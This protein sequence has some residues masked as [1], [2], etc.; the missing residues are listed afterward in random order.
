MSIGEDAAQT[1]K[2]LLTGR[3]IARMIYEHCKVSDTDESVLDFSEI[4]KGELKNDTQWFNRDEMK[5]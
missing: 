2:R 3:H 5:P 1:G 4:V